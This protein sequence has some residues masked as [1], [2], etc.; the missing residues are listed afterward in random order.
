MAW[1]KDLCG[2]LM[3]EH[4]V[5]RETAM[6]IVGLV[7]D[8]KE[9]SYQQGYHKGYNDGHKKGKESRNAD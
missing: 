6:S 3:K 8:F 9:Q 2:K 7:A 4:G 5:N 1:D